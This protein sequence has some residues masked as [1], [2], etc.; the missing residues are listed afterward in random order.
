MAT[1][2][3]GQGI[4]PLPPFKAWLAS[5]IP[6]VY[7]NTMT[8]YEELVALIKYLQDTVVPAVN[9]NA[10]AI[11]TISNAVEQLQKYVDDYF[12]NLNVQEEINNKL[13]QM[14]TDGTF[15]DVIGQYLR[16]EFDEIN[17]KIDTNV[18]NLENQLDTAITAESNARSQADD[19]LRSQITALASGSPIP[20]ASTSA[21]TDQSKIYVNTTDGKWYY[22]N[23]SAWTAGGTYQSSG[24]ASGSVK[25]SSLETKLL[26]SLFIKSTNVN[27]LGKLGLLNNTTENITTH[28]LVLSGTTITFSSNFVSNY[29]WCIYRCSYPD[30]IV[31]GNVKTF[32]TDTSYQFTND[33]YCV[34]AW[35]P[36]DDNW[37]SE[38]YTVDRKH[39]LDSNDITDIT[40]YY[41]KYNDMIEGIADSEYKEFACSCRAFTSSGDIWLY[42]QTRWGLNVAIKSTSKVKVSMLD[43]RFNY[44][45]ITVK[46][47]EDNTNFRYYD[48]LSDSGWLSAGETIIPA[49][50]LFVFSMRTPS[51]AD[52]RP[53][54][55]E[56]R[57][58][59][60]ISPYASMSYIDNA[61]NQVPALI[62]DYDKFVKGINHRGY[63]TVAPE[64]TI[65]AFK[66]SA[67]NGFKYVE[68]DVQFTSDSI[69]VMIHDDTIDRTSNGTGRVDSMTYSQISQY[70]FG[71]WK[72]SEYAGTKIP[73]LYEFL[74]C[75]KDCGLTPYIE[76][77][78]STL[79]DAQYDIIINA[80]KQYGMMDKVT[81]ISF[82]IA[83][84][85]GM[86]SRLP[87]A[88]LGLVYNGELTDGI[89]SLMG[90][91]SG[92]NESFI[93][94]WINTI[95]TESVNKCIAA[96]Y[97]LEI[98]TVD[99]DN[100][101][102]SLP[103]CV[104]GVTSDNKIAGKVLLE[105]ALS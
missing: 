14:V 43:S 61:V 12:E 13:D 104:T 54:I 45:I 1:L 62:P 21:M 84:L 47:S 32:S 86:H 4:I 57:K 2:P 9:D 82:N 3:K 10:S 39:K 68:S 20:V 36:I 24:I 46:L 77:K 72:S 88:R 16:E 51:N 58:A 33:E 11:T 99:T 38:T 5:N 90:S 67:E 80:L 35:Q 73:T 71:S 89:I 19:N 40:Y 18:E 105:N 100:E 48:V 23:G 53:L 49:N 74:D 85:Q 8:Y 6:A 102:L 76:L 97:P 55:A 34:I 52:L 98:W 93:D 15:E 101:I 56:M 31:S 41:P 70:D 27:A 96:G 17:N 26:D 25:T 50:T 95:T 81:F 103:D 78:T 44:S 75:C 66:L 63:N 94:L 69:P 42:N 87:K 91:I 37:S 29:K 22:W 60:S 83:L 7:D 65:P 79:T 28:L 59:I 30:G 92:D 64:N